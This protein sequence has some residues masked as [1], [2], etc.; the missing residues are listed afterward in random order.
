MLDKFKVPGFE[1]RRI[2]S[3][4][5]SSIEWVGTQLTYVAVVAR[6]SPIVNILAFKHN[7]NRLRRLYSVNLLPDL[8]NPEQPELNEDQSYLDF[9]YQVKMSLDGVFLA[10]TQL[11][12]A[13]KLLRMPPVLNPLDADKTPPAGADNPGSRDSMNKPPTV[14]GK[15]SVERT[16]AELGSIGSIGVT[17]DENPTI[18]LKN[19]LEKFAFEELQLEKQ[20][21]TTIAAKKK[22]EFVD[23]FAPE[24]EK[25]E[26]SQDETLAEISKQSLSKK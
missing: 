17:S 3:I 20:L 16:S 21:I 13:V 10:V 15:T 25:K 24:E 14:G 12:G 2:I 26:A 11:T 19:D 18:I 7:E 23:P 9:P 4:T 22:N 1:S 6:G 8:A 5:S